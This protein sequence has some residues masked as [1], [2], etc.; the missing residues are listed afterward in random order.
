MVLKTRFCPKCGKEVDSIV[1]GLCADCFVAKAGVHL[2]ASAEVKVCKKCKTIFL[3]G[4]WVDSALSPQRHL[5]QILTSKVVLP[6]DAVLESLK[7]EN[8]KEGTVKIVYSV[9]GKKFTENVHSNLWIRIVA[10]KECSQRA[11]KAYMGILQIRARTNVR[12]LTDEVIAFAQKYKT[13]IVKVEEVAQGADMQILSKDAARHLASEIRRKFNLRM[14]TSHE[15]YSWDKV[16]CRPKSRIN[17][18]LEQRKQ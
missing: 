16:K 14:S 17:I 3:E 11:G 12:K 9:D 4:M 1:D 18:L 5:E 15:E 6:D 7:I 10:C 13:N 8:L 2:P